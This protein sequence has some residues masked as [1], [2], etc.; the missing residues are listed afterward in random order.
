MSNI[1]TKLKK[2]PSLFFGVLTIPMI[3]SAIQSP[4]FSTDLFLQA[5]VTVLLVM[6]LVIIYKVVNLWL[7]RD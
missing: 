7:K 2:A 3:I 1:S 6:N 5:S 4:K